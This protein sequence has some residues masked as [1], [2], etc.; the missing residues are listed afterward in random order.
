MPRTCPSIRAR[1]RGPALQEA[2]GVLVADHAQTLQ[3]APLRVEENDAG[4][5]EQ[6]EALEQRLVLGAV[7]GDVGLQQ[8]HAVQLRL[9]AR[10]AE[11][12]RLHFLAGHAPV[13]I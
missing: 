9:D 7:A 3:F 1:P 6:V 4:R 2:F 8:Q 11:G 10:I 12:E 5:A 13:G